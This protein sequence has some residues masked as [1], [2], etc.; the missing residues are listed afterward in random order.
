[1]SQG[2]FAYI[3]SIKPGAAE[4]VAEIIPEL[5]SHSELAELQF[6]TGHIGEHEFLIA[7]Y[8]GERAAWSTLGHEGF[9]SSLTPHLV[10]NDSTPPWC[11]CETVCQLRPDTPVP[12]NTPTW[13]VAVT[14]LREEKEAGYRLLH[15]HVWPGVIDAIGDSSISIF[16]V[17]LTELD[18][19]P[20]LFHRMK[21]IGIDFDS[22][23][24]KMAAN[25]VNQ[26]WWKVTDACQSP[27]PEATEKSEIW[28]PLK[29]L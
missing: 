11:M 16:D 23:M 28:L 10:H 15:N 3:S 27:L 22:D 12:S 25:P 4:L 5:P 13:Q 19:R 14:G 29:S 1:M 18:G 26:R 2:S 6:H 21:Y 9:L 8:Y 17:F 20:Y 24:E 7:T